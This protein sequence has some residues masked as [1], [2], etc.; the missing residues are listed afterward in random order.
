MQGVLIVD[1]VRTPFGGRNG[2]LSGWHPAELAARCTAALLERTGLP[3]DEVDD[4]LLGCVTWAGAQSFNVARTA[5]LAAG[6]PL[7]TPGVTL[8]RQ[9]ASGLS[10]LALGAAAA[11]AG[12]L[13]VAV[14]GGVEVTSVAPPGAS[15][16]VGFGSPFPPAVANR[17]HAEG[18]LVPPGPAAELLAASAGL[19]RE[20]LDAYSLDSVQ[21]AARAQAEGRFVGQLVALGARRRDPDTGEVREGPGPALDEGVAQS[22]GRDAAA[23]AAAK[24]LYPDGALVTALNAA[25][26]ADGAAA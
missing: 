16:G 17:F 11:A 12:Q 8:D 23:F 15:V 18:G 5:A 6:L 19:S 22:G 1:A 10:A 14:V 7:R 9:G 24:P 21:R 13:G 4:L 20:A 26:L 3:G 25:P 2:A